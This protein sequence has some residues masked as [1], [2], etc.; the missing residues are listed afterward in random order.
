MI[1]AKNKGNTLITMGC[2]SDNNCKAVIPMRLDLTATMKAATCAT[3][4]A[5]QMKIAPVLI[6]DFDLSGKGTKE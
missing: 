1:G 3:I 4:K 6:F 2:F 5:K